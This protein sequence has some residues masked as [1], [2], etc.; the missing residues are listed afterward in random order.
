MT[1]QQ[2][3]NLTR[4]LRDAEVELHRARENRERIRHC[5]RCVGQ[6]AGSLR[7]SPFGL[8]VPG[9]GVETGLDTVKEWPTHAETAAAW[10]LADDLESRVERL[11]SRLAD[12]RSNL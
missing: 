5:L 2:F 1:D 11:Q 6:V 7:W 4:D 8:A 3:I 10:R 12:A 9:S